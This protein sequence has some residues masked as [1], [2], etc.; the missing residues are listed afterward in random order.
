[1]I[2]AFVMLF[3]FSVTSFS[4][5]TADQQANSLVSGWGYNFNITYP[6]GYGTSWFYRIL[7]FIS[8]LNSNTSAI[9]TNTNDIPKIFSSLGSGNNTQLGTISGNTYQIYSKLL[10][11]DGYLS[12]LA[13]DVDIFKPYIQL[14]DGLK[15]NSDQLLL[16][17]GARP[18]G[19]SV[20]IINAIND[21]RRYAS[22]VS[23]D[24]YYY[25]D[26]G[27]MQVASPDYFYA[28]SRNLDQLLYNVCFNPI[29]DSYVYNSDYGLYVEEKTNFLSSISRSLVPLSYDYAL[30]NQHQV[31]FVDYANDIQ[32]SNNYNWST[33]IL[34]SLNYTNDNLSRLA[35]VLADDHDI[36]IKKDSQDN[37]T[38]VTDNFISPDGANSIKPA[39]IGSVS[40][41]GTSVKDTFATGVSPTGAFDVINS[42]DPWEWFTQATADSLVTGGGAS[43]LSIDNNVIV[44]DY[45]SSNFSDLQKWL[46]EVAG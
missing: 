33:A 24:F 10:S 42:S 21:L 28:T 12:T 36:Q 27:D 11:S 26:N 3:S 16:S 34:S 45:Y 9:R 4:A 37:A 44:T 29:Y 38:A 22:Q 14:I 15:S 32:I 30:N 7:Y 8:N 31:R 5:V 41:L 1:M 17:V 40:N 20:S 43:T 6:S 2:L 25:T 35:Y 18:D 46:E 13:T 19:D 39:D 23:G